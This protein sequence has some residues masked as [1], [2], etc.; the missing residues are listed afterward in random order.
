M[1][2]EVPVQNGP[3]PASRLHPSQI[4][5]RVSSIASRRR[6]VALTGVL[7]PAPFGTSL[8][9]GLVGRVTVKRSTS[10]APEQDEQLDGQ[11]RRV[12]R[13]RL[14]LV[15]VIL[16]PERSS[17]DEERAVGL[18]SVSSRLSDSHACISR[19]SFAV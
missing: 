4:L 19:S 7:D 17:S 14:E 5:R 13:F 15:K 10:Q 16:D 1:D 18:F 12:G 6:N 9:F 3:K 11:L 8:S 2:V